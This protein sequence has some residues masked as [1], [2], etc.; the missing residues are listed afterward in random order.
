MSGSRSIVVAG[1]YGSPRDSSDAWRR[2][3]EH[4]PRARSVLTHN[5][6]VIAAP[7]AAGDLVAAAKAEYANS[8]ALRAEF[9][10]LDTY[11][12]FCK[13]MAS[14]RV[15]SFGRPVQR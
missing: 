5:G 13:A 3:E 12:A 9:I 15:K 10:N 14:G 1:R 6:E 2:H 4:D 11:V 7:P 8:A